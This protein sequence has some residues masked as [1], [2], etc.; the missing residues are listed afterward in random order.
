MDGIYHLVYCFLLNF[1]GLQYWDYWQ[2]RV[3]LMYENLTFLRGKGVIFWIFLV[4]NDA[5]VKKCLS[6]R[7]VAYGLT[8][9]N[10]VICKL[11]EMLKNQ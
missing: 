2:A 5:Y 7:C 11:F 1:A 6:L 9:S 8:L 3:G 4:K 10:G